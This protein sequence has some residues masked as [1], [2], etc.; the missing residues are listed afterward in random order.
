[1]Y[2][3]NY[4]KSSPRHAGQQLYFGI[5]LLDAQIFATKKDTSSTSPRPTNK[6]RSNKLRFRFWLIYAFLYDESSSV[7]KE[8]RTSQLKRIGKEGTFCFC[9]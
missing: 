7:R 4:T 3:N 8:R 6:L 9:R 2:I 1:M 5:S